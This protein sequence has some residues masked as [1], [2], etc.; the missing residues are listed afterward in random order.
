MR[1]GEYRGVLQMLSEDAERTVDHTGIYYGRSI[2]GYKRHSENSYEGCRPEERSHDLHNLRRVP[3]RS[4]QRGEKYR[5]HSQHHMPVLWPASTLYRGKQCPLHIGNASTFRLQAHLIDIYADHALSPLFPQTVH[6]NRIYSLTIYCPTTYPNGPPLVKF[7]SKINL[8]CVDGR[9]VVSRSSFLA[10]DVGSKGERVL[11][12]IR[13]DRLTSRVSLRCTRGNGTTP[14][15]TSLSPSGG[16][17]YLRTRDTI[18]LIFSSPAP[19]PSFVTIPFLHSSLHESSNG[20]QP[21]SIHT[22]APSTATWLLP[23]TR[24]PLN[25]PK[26]PNSPR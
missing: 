19:W 26:A 22:F 18:P 2:L 17:S 23:S 3:R 12:G 21:F 8:P 13:P 24:R 6:E 20:I 16:T 14:W 9:G 4:K 15:N 25:Q 1:N 10:R 5:L 7:E 11:I